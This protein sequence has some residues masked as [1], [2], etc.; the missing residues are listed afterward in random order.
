MNEQ[1]HNAIL[2][3]SI[4]Y[5]ISAGLTSMKT[6]VFFLLLS[7]YL[8][9]LTFQ[10]LDFND[11]GFHVAFYQQIF[12][13]PASVQYGFWM[14]L[15]GIFG[16]GFMKL[17][18]FLGLWGIRFEGVIITVSTIAI[19]YNLLKKYLHTGYLRL[20][21]IMLVL[22]INE[23]PRTFYYNNFSAFCYFLAACLIFRGL[24]DNKNLFVL[25]CGLVIGL[26]IFN[27]TPNLLGAG[28]ILSIPF[29][30]Y[31]VKGSV[32]N[33]IQKMCVFA[34]GFVLALLLVYISMILLGHLEIFINSMK[35]VFGLSQEVRASDG[36]DGSY[37]ISKLFVINVLEYLGAARSILLIVLLIMISGFIGTF[38]YAGNPVIKTMV[39]LI[40]LLIVMGVIAGIFLGWGNDYRLVLLFT[41]ISM[42][43]VFLLFNQKTDPLIRLI[44]FLGGFILLVH[45]FGS[46]EGITTVIAYSMW[47]SFPVSIDLVSKIQKADIQLSVTN[48]L[49]KRSFGIKF[50]ELQLRHIRIISLSLIILACLYNVIVFPDYFDRHD[51]RQM[52]YSVNNKNVHGILTTKPRADALNQLLEAS[53]QYIKP[54]DTVFAFDCLPMY[55]YMTETK[56][57]VRNPCIWY[58]TTNLFKAELD[59]AESHEKSLPVVVRQKI[60]TIGSGSSWPEVLPPGNYLQL[61]RNLRKNQFFDEFLIRNNYK[62]VWSSQ[63]FEIF[64]P[65]I[66]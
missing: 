16:G 53:S 22:F 35:M 54:G 52:L 9:L 24:R 21:I 26:N 11:E 63:F 43:S 45:P 50:N 6:N 44:V 31:I 2:S 25:F 58:Y 37:R 40:N 32:R 48:M 14:W 5:K 8:V 29:Y 56:S 30:G 13:D 19:S 10:G 41:G 28:M 23:Y 55:H 46:S 20:S 36:L 64:I 66:R 7:I 12:N 39:R 65:Q 27:R 3:G 47:I 17:F 1:P 57:Y 49:N 61:P 62:E 18:P 4:L 15:T 42:L 34:G 59:Y 38:S 60:N 51:R 33:Q